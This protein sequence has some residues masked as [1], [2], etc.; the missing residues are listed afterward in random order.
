[1]TTHLRLGS[2]RAAAIGVGVL[3]PLAAAFVA[4]QAPTPTTSPTSQAA[5]VA[6]YNTDVAP[7]L[8][9]R[10][11][12]CH[13][14]GEAGPM[15]LLT[16]AQTRPY[17]AAIRAATRAKVMPPWFADP[18]Y[19]SFKNSHVLTDVQIST[20]AAWVEGGAPEG[21][22]PRVRCLAREESARRHRARA[23][24]VPSADTHR[25]GDG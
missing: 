15:P 18:R 11:A 8:H 20:L 12:S 19:G 25:V 21:A 9:Q 6:S 7:I 14:P 5:P 17:A 4:A 13:R 23:Q 24:A 22:G 1:M 2:V 16:Y 3:T 10:C